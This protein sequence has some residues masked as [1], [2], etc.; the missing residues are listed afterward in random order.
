MNSFGK[1]IFYVKYYHIARREWKTSDKIKCNLGPRVT[2]SWGRS[3]QTCIRRAGR[4]F[5]CTDRDC[6]DVFVDIV[7]QGRSLEQTL[8]EGYNTVDY[9]LAGEFGGVCPDSRR[10]IEATL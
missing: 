8:N 3:E 10:D 1:L 5:L 2:K 4:L 7:N 6:R 9:R